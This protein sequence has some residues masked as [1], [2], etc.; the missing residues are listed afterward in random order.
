MNN[1]GTGYLAPPKVNIIGTGAGAT[2]EAEWDSSTG[3]VTGITI[4]NGGSGYWRVPNAMVNGSGGSYPVSPQNQ[5]AAIII[6]TGY[7]ENLLYR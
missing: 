7:I 5:G 6:S 4:T 3:S 1:N 2:A